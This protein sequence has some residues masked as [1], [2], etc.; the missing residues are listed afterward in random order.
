MNIIRRYRPLTLLLACWP[1]AVWSQTTGA[2]ALPV[3]RPT[4]KPGERWEYRVLDAWNNKETDRVTLT[5][6]RQEGE[7]LL[8]AR[9]TKAQ[10][11]PVATRADLDGNNCVPMLDN[12]QEVCAR[13]TVFPLKVG[14]QTEYSK[15]PFPNRQGH[16]QGRCTVAGAESVTVPAGQFDT[17]KIE[18][19]GYWNF[20]AGQ[21]S[22]GTLLQT[23]W[24]APS[25]GRA[26]RLYTE[27]HTPQGQPNNKTMTELVSHSRPAS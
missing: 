9:Q 24:Y 17:L 7:R 13:I 22:S 14:N 23:Y 4:W 15:F 26:V 6:E 19:K 10:P 20:T 16:S 5:F 11:D 25:I 12:S 27:S 1:V 18:C 2:G 8:G 21:P 3:E